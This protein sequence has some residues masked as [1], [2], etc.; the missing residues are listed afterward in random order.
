MTKTKRYLS[1]VSS[2]AVLSTV[3]AGC[4]AVTGKS[5]NNSSTVNQSSTTSGAASGVTSLTGAGS[6]FDYPF[7]NRAFYA[8][9][10]ASGVQVNYQSVGSGAGIEQFTAKTV[11]F[12]ASDV[13][14]NSDELS[15]AKAS[16][17]NVIEIPITLG[18][19]AIA[20]NLPTVTK[21]LRFTPKVLADIYLGHVKTWNSP[22]IAKI[23]PGIKLPQIPIVVVHR[24]DG[25][26]TT[27]IFTDYLSSVSPEWKKKVGK[28][29]S[30]NW[31]VGIGGKGNE[32]VAGNVHNTVGAIGYVELA[33]A[34]QTKMSYGLMQ[35]RA[36]KFVAPSPVT[37]MAAAATKPSV[38]PT[39]F[40]IVNAAG[41][42]SYPITG[43][44][45]VLLYQHYP[46][47][48]KEVALKT[49][50]QWMETTGQAQ[51][52]SVKYV[53]LPKNIQAA[54]LRTLKSMK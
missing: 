45:W 34:L 22:E 12:G 8:Y 19:E 36:G 5:T 26:G 40:S 2:M 18:G 20:Y 17:G 10:T 29:K 41:A 52:V 51:A 49:L 15:A 16:G 9:Q 44:S 23:N 38:S 39:N 6:T 31:P 3:V 42:K 11:D 50:F 25:S 1:I 48:A 28:D 27:Y 30:V 35:N 54:A 47:S 37:V 4:G 46:S 53:S 13:P 14:M 24:S 33:Y 43:Y 7:F 21:Q 32:A